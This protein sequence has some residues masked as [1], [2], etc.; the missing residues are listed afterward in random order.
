M[1]FFLLLSSN[2]VVCVERVGRRVFCSWKLRDKANM[3]ATIWEK[4]ADEELMPLLCFDL[5]VAHASSAHNPL[6]RASHLPC[7]LQ[8]G[9]GNEYLMSTTILS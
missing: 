5:N 3:A 9:L 8:R 7:R 2:I 1:L 4:N 6:A